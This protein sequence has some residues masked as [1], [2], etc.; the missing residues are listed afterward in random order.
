MIGSGA[1]AVTLVPAMA[2][3]AAHV[4]MLQRSPTYIISFPAKDAIANALLRVFGDRLGHRLARRKNVRMQ[5]VIYRLS[6]RHPGSCAALIRA[7][8]KAQL[9]RGYDID[10]HFKPAY[11]PWDQRLCLVPNGDLFKSISAGDASVVTD[12][13]D[14]FTETGIRLRSG[15]ELEADVVVTATGLNMLAFGGIEFI[16]DGETVDVA[17]TV[18][19]KGMMLS[20]M[21][22]FA[23]SIGYTNTAWT[24][25][26]DLVCKYLCRLLHHLDATGMD[27]CVPQ[28]DP[29]MPTRPMLDLAAGYVKRGVASFPRQGEGS[30]QLSMDYDRDVHTYREGAIDDGAVRFAA[31]SARPALLAAA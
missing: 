22:N 31:P 20:G 28:A 5:R 27:R 6:R 17:Q 19:Y 30:W 11:D 18:V 26:V 23:F 9:P 29:D 8:Q 2:G 3:D 4:T 1:T 25:K 7:I 24:L 12:H 14:T 15:A 10:S 16:V 21:P 13:V